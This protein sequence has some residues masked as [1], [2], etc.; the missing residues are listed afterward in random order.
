[1]IHDSVY[2]NL[3]YPLKI[4][5]M[6]QSKDELLEW[7]DKCGLA[8]KEKQYA[9]SLSS[10]ER[11]KLSIA[12]ALVFQPKVVMIDETLSNMDPDSVVLFEQLIKD[13]QGIKPIT[14]IVV[15]HQLAHIY[16][17]CD[18]IHF[19]NS[20]TILSSGKTE[21]IFSN[22]DNPTI[23]QYLSKYIIGN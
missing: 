13:I 12:R 16:R 10:G 11:Q 7:L 1:M 18:E 8:G 3:I 17:I 21:D 15:S 4:R 2:N 6:K 22:T 14:W 5:K 20:G 9:P 23:K 19:M